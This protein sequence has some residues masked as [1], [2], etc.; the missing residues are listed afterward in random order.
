MS[1]FVLNESNPISSV[2]NSPRV[3]SFP[4]MST[5]KTVRSHSIHIAIARDHERIK[6]AER[7]TLKLNQ[8]LVKLERK[9]NSHA[10]WNERAANRLLQ[11]NSLSQ[12][13]DHPPMSMEEFLVHE[14]IRQ[15]KISN[16]KKLANE[17]IRRH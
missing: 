12:P 7:Q 11:R 9:M 13:S 10:K 5:N 16:A 15:D 8:D 14:R 4:K 1:I 17:N 3:N 6:M 2:Q